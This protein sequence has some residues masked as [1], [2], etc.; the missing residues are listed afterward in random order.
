MTVL[1]KAYT[2]VSC[3]AFTLVHIAARYHCAV[4]T[5]ACVLSTQ[6]TATESEQCYSAVHSG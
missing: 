2:R 4:D 6:A 3:Q 1:Y 5:L